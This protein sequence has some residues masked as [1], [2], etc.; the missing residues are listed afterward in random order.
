MMELMTLNRS[1]TK[2]SVKLCARVFLT[3]INGVTYFV[4]TG[5]L[6]AEVGLVI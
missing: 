1:I 2:V 4:K 6:T 5:D 3:V